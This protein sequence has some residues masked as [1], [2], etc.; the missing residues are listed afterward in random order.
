MLCRTWWCTL[1]SF[2]GTTDI[3]ISWTVSSVGFALVSSLW[4]AKL[5]VMLLSRFA[6]SFFFKQQ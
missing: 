1:L 3:G 5:L 6:Y 4:V 2:I